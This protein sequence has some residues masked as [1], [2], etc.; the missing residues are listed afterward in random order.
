MR[1]ESLKFLKE[2]VEAPSPSGFEG[3]AQRVWRAEVEQYADAVRTD[4][5]GNAIAVK[6]GGGAPRLMLAGH[7]DELGFIVRYIDD[8]GYL[9]FATI[10]GFDMNTIPA[11]RVVVHTENGPV[12]G[13][14][15]KKA[16][17]TMDEE[18]RKKTPKAHELWIDIGA[19]DKEEAASLVAVGDPVTYTDGFEL[20]RNDLAAARGFDDKMGSFVVAEAMRLASEQTLGAALFSVSTVQEEI[21]LRGARTSTFGIDPQV[22]IAVDVT[23]ATDS[24]GMN[25]KR[26]GDLKIGGGPVITRGANIN[27]VV[28]KLLV[29]TAR[30]E[31]IPYQIEA[32]PG[33]TGTDANA[34][35]IT[36]AGVA[37]GLVSVPLRYMHTPVETLSLEDLDNTAKLL[38]AFAAR[39]DGSIDFTP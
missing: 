5:H 21:G 29:D 30:E 20:L 10:G 3:P 23:H 36:R 13:V 9:S 17:H 34:M 33:G 25:K 8:E 22:G 18:D 38:A 32:E 12:F 26:E 14:I 24:P 16:V 19:N 4:V 11:R 37:T 1:E 7:C 35:Q 2:L 28:A 27:P 6:N 15:G 31:S 39:L